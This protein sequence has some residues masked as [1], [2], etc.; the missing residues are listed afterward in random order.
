MLLYGFDKSI[1]S[2]MKELRV[3]VKRDVFRGVH[4]HELNEQEQKEIIT[5][6]MNYWK[7]ESY[8]ETDIP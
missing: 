1:V 6:R 5:G 4:L 2:M 3:I 7:N 8:S